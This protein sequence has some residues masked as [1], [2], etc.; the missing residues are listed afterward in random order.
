MED[1]K[2][3]LGKVIKVWTI[4]TT[5]PFCGKLLECGSASVT[6]DDKKGKKLIPDTSIR[7]VDV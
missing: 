7:S 3:Y 2:K 1:L 6:I 4:E 5:I